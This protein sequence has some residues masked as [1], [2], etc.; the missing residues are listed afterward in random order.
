MD[1]PPFDSGR[2]ARMRDYLSIEVLVRVVEKGSFS[3]AGQSL[4]LTPSAVSKHVSRMER[5]LG[6]SLVNRSTHELSL[7]EAGKIFHERCVKILREI[8]SARDAAREA[9]AGLGGT[10]RLHLTPGLTARQ[11]VL[12]A[13]RRFSTKHPELTVDVTMTLENVD[14]VEGGFD[15]AIRSDTSKDVGPRNGSVEYRELAGCN[16]L[17][18]ASKDYFRRHAK[19]KQ[20]RDLVHHDCLLFVGQP[21][22]DRWWFTDGRRKYGVSVTGHFRANDW[23]AIHEAALAGRG[24]ARMQVLEGKSLNTK[25]GLEVIFES[26][27]VCDRA[28]WAV[29]PRTPNLPMKVSAF[30]AHL[31][32]ELK[33]KD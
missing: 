19:P 28:V 31:S 18:C 27:A 4:N 21:S 5:E 1:T 15:L 10:L 3:A 22:Y 30:L 33:A 29:Y 17:I 20:P 11:F 6:V 24:I 9:S 25:R 8:E 32:A 12:P 7:T 13:L 26:E 2:G 16:Y 14:V 23:L